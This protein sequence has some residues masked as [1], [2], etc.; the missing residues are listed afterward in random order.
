MSDIK[1]FVDFRPSLTWILTSV[2]VW[3]FRHWMLTFSC[4]ILNADIWHW[5]TIPTLNNQLVLQTTD[6]VW[7]FWHWNADLV[8]RL[9]TLSEFSDIECWPCLKT[10][11]LSRL[12]WHWM[13]TLFWRLLT[14]SDSTDIESWPCLE[15]IVWPLRYWMLFFFLAG[16]QPYLTLY[17]ILVLQIY[18]FVL[19]LNADLVFKTSDI[20][21]LVQHW[22]LNFV[23]LALSWHWLLTLSCRLLLRVSR[24]LTD[25]LISITSL[26]FNCQNILIKWDMSYFF[27]CVSVHKCVHIWKSDFI[28]IAYKLSNAFEIPCTQTLE[29]HWLFLLHLASLVKFFLFELNLFQCFLLCKT[30]WIPLELTNFFKEISYLPIKCIF[31]TIIMN[32]VRKIFYLV[33]LY[34]ACKP[35]MGTPWRPHS[36]H[37]FP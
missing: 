6:H 1:F 34:A 19:K 15:E 36:I 7:L 16:L 8:W 14:L 9:L 5:L 32:R 20:A 35:L 33:Y 23:D 29:I 24:L 25:S 22:M 11:Y 28:L 13:P 31:Y 17:A 4:I 37:V 26:F 30:D 2:T 18:N 3:L 12:I 27:V 10:S 21:W